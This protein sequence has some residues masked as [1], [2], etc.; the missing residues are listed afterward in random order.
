MREA[1][2]AEVARAYAAADDAIRQAQAQAARTVSMQP[3]SIP[4]PPFEFRSE[5]GHI[6]NALNALHQ[7][8]YVLEVEHGQRSRP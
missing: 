7:I 6:E 4:V 2:D 8:D 3:L 5:T 1:A